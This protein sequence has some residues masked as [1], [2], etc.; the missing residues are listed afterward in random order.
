MNLPDSQ[1]EVHRDPQ[2]A[3]YTTRVVVGADQ[4][5]TTRAIPSTAIKGT[6]LLP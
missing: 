4:T 3:T 1:I 5:F 6:D 2:G